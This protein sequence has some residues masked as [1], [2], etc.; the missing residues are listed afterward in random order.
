MKKTAIVTLG[1]INLIVGFLLL[2]YFSVWLAEEITS[3]FTWGLLILIPA[4][5]IFILGV[6]TLIRD[7]VKF[8]L[9]GLV[10][11]VVEGFYIFVL[12]WVLSWCM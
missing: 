8:G 5:L 9:C 6:Y 10:I 4:L 12:S 2:M 11:C 1:T 3:A 7:N